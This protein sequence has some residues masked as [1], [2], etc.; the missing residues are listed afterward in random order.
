M[1]ADSLGA[2]VLHST[3]CL[4]WQ[5]GESLIFEGKGPA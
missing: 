3:Y 5:E 2:A 1:T 4:I